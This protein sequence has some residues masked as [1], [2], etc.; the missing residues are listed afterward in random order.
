MSRQITKYSEPDCKRF[1]DPIVCTG[2]GK[3]DEENKRKRKLLV[4]LQSFSIDPA[5]SKHT[6][7]I[8]KFLQ[9]FNVKGFH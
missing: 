1:Q 3:K 9:E 8:R 6:L 4:P 5:V 7:Y 2:V